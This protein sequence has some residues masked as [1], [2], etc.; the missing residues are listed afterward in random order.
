MSSDDVPANPGYVLS[1]VWRALHPED[2]RL[3]EAGHLERFDTREAAVEAARRLREHGPGAALGNGERIPADAVDID[4]D[5]RRG[6]G[7]YYRHATGTE[8]AG[9]TIAEGRAGIA[10]ARAALAAVTR[11]A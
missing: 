2:D 3:I 9:V 1:V 5:V 4:I 11:P 8:L 6:P 10:N 7:G